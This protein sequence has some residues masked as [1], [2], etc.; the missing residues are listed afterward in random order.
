MKSI[1]FKIYSLL[2]LLFVELASPHIIMAQ[3]PPTVV[4]PSPQAVGL[5]RFG[6]W[7]VS[8]YTGVPNISIPLHTISYRDI[9]IPISVNYHASGIRVEDEASPIGLGWSLN[10]GGMISRTIHGEDDLDGLGKGFPLVNQ[11]GSTT[12][13][14]YT[15]QFREFKGYPFD[16]VV[17]AFDKTGLVPWTFLQEF[18]DKKIDPEPDIFQYSFL[19]FSGKFV[20]EQG[21]TINNLVDI[22]GYPN[23][24][25]SRYLRCRTLEGSDV[26]ILFDPL[27]NSWLIIDGGGYQY[28]FRTI[29]Y[30]EIHTAS[31][32]GI[33]G[34]AC[35]NPTWFDANALNITAWYLDKIISPSNTEV[36]FTYD[37]TPLYQEDYS[38]SPYLSK[39]QLRTD[40]VSSEVVEV[41][42]LAETDKHEDIIIPGPISITCWSGVR[43][44]AEKKTTQLNY[45]NHVY[46]KEIVTP[47]EKVEFT[48]SSR[49]DMLDGYDPSNVNTRIYGIYGFIHSSLKG[50]QRYTGL[51]IKDANNQLFKE[52]IFDN[53]HYFNPN[54]DS[55]LK[56]L[57]L[58]GVQECGSSSNDCINPY[59]FY[60]NEQVALP[61]KDSYAQ[62]FWGFYNGENDNPSLIPTGA[63][64]SPITGQITFTG[65]ANRQPSAY[66]MQAGILETIQY[67]TGGITDFEFEPN[68]YSVFGE[69]AFSVT[70]F[71]ENPNETILEEEIN[72]TSGDHTYTFQLSE[73]CEVKVTRIVEYLQCVTGAGCNAPEPLPAFNNNTSLNYLEIYGG[74]PPNTLNVNYHFGEYYNQWQNACSGNNPVGDPCQFQ[75]ESTLILGPGYYNV[76]LRNY[77]DA[78]GSEPD[79]R[80]YVKIDCKRIASRDIPLDANRNVYAKV[81]GGLRIKSIKSTAYS[82]D[83]KPLI[84]RYEY[85][86]DSA[87]SQYSSGRLML[88]PNHHGL[89]EYVANAASNGNCFVVLRSLEGSSSN[90][91]AISSRSQGNVI[92]YDRVR[93]YS[94]QDGS[95]GYVEYVF[96]NQQEIIPDKSSSNNNYYILPSYP[97]ITHTDNGLLKEQGVYNNNGELLR[98]TVNTYATQNLGTTKGVLILTN[99]NSLFSGIYKVYELPHDQHYLTETEE[100]TYE[101]RQG[102]SVYDSIVNRSKYFYHTV[103][104]YQRLDSVVTEIGNVDLA[105]SPQDNTYPDA[106]ISVSERIYLD[107]VLN[108]GFSQ[109]QT[110]LASFQSDTLACG[111]TYRINIASCG[112]INDWY[113]NL[114]CMDG[115]LTAYYDCYRQAYYTLQSCR[116]NNSCTT[117]DGK[118]R[119]NVSNARHNMA[120]ENRTSIRENSLSV[121]QYIGSQK[122]EYATLDGGNVS[123]SPTPNYNGFDPT[124]NHTDILVPEKFYTG[125]FKNPIVEG[126]YQANTNHSLRAEVTAYDPT[127]GNVWEQKKA[128]DIPTSY[129][130][131]YNNSLPVAEVIGASRQELEDAFSGSLPNMDNGIST[132]DENI[133][134]IHFADK[135]QVLITTYAYTPHL[136]I[137]KMTDPNG[138]MTFYEYDELNRLRLV[139][140]KTQ[141]EQQDNPNAKGVILKRYEYHYYG[142]SN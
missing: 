137:I 131:G 46:L 51:K 71:E 31:C 127:N 95:E 83:P 49:T 110:C 36:T 128:N 16:P 34:G 140:Y 136:G 27:Y 11:D 132:T 101:K 123:G 9:S 58:Q 119:T 6:D 79:L 103:N 107:D 28:I 100:I 37:L 45:R 25:K 89:H 94:Y 133:L 91:N 70:D 121:K 77:S 26:T 138:N 38:V 84:K 39:S 54:G 99:S 102:V 108:C 65:E 97:T 23:L 13:R 141:A 12:S 5:G 1:D 3:E 126:N 109:M 92:G 48:K 80:T 142:D 72:Y 43:L 120:S 33:S 30:T 106:K 122:T 104:N 88:F 57:K 93:E 117:I 111:D 113:D 118:E 73:L 4:R 32:G 105:K 78:G 61:A 63:Y 14:I 134:R 35:S 18:Q 52:I 10:A 66:H 98:K 7:P 129:L 76:V 124:L 22:A 17:A 47:F 2:F 42:T 67:P 125:E 87:G 115:V 135:K 55:K 29:E 69:G 64:K 96:Q 21:Q 114:N 112:E 41:L 68:D 139:R 59:K 62:D 60:Y 50:P 116:Y 85:V 75:K 82:G 20:F 53:N 44:P 130:W 56:R 24:Q 40:K 81:G 15:G 19:E 86:R 8:T 90:T 74:N